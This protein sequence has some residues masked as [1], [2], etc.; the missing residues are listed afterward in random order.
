MSPF[1]IFLFPAFH[2]MLKI[3]LLPPSRKDSSIRRP[4]F[5]L[6]KT[7]HHTPAALFLLFLTL[8]VFLSFLVHMKVWPQQD[9]HNFCVLG[10]SDGCHGLILACLV[11]LT[12]LPSEPLDTTPPARSSPTRLETPPRKRPTIAMYL[13]SF[14]ARLS[15]R[16]QVRLLVSGAYHKGHKVIQG[17]WC[18]WGIYQCGMY[19]MGHW[20]ASW[21]SSCPWSVP[22]HCSKL[23]GNNFLWTSF[24]LCHY[25][26]CKWCYYCYLVKSADTWPDVTIKGTTKRTPRVTPHHPPHLQLS[27]SNSISTSPLLDPHVILTKVRHIVFAHRC[28]HTHAFVS[29]FSIQ[30]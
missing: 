13:I 18:R 23:H 20:Q 2:S 3:P 17:V 15:P 10:I 24:Y 9:F 30:V 29:T 6:C 27:W 21:S 12:P 1:Y 4:S 28:W 14:C 25:R 7:F 11:M 5:P 26:T 19:Q 8:N 22:S 16:K